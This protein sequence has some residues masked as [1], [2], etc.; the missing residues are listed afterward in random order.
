MPSNFIEAAIL[1]VQEMPGLT[2]GDYARVAVDRRL[3]WS[4]AQDPV[5]SF[6]ATLS[7]Y[8]SREDGRYITR[9]FMNGAYRY[10]PVDGPTGNGLKGL[11]LTSGRGNQTR[12]MDLIGGGVPR[13][14]RDSAPW[15]EGVHSLRRAA[16]RAIDDPIGSSTTPIEQYLLGVVCYEIERYDDAVALFRAALVA[17]LDGGYRAKAERFR[18]I[19]EMKADEVGNSY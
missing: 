12:Q 18:D 19:C 4:H 15:P 13:G 7:S 3:V 9:R 11:A 8:M 1:L 2:A 5:T 10:F 16:R 14:K 17:G 6:C